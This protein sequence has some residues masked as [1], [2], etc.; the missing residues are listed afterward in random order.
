MIVLISC[1]SQKFK[2]PLVCVFTPEIPAELI[3]QSITASADSSA[4]FR[5]VII[6]HSKSEET[7]FSRIKI[8]NL[9]SGN[10]VAGAFDKKGKCTV[11]V[12]EGL[13]SVQIV[14]LFALNLTIDSVKINQGESCE[15]LV[16]MGELSNFQTVQMK[17]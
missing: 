5:I 6:E 9:D 13:Y 10:S 8:T 14:P 7:S 3:R 17:E 4:E 1:A 15:L 2:G 16:K 11:A 12:S